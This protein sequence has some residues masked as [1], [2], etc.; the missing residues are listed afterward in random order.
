[1]MVKILTGAFSGMVSGIILAVFGYAKNA[2]EKF[3]FR[4]SA[5]T[6]IL[7]VFVGLVAVY[8]GITYFETQDWFLTVGALTLFEYSLK[9]FWRRIVLP[10][11]RKFRR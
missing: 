10:I 3:N 7:G 9:T 6:V 5:Q 2:G 11:K 4:K 1:M 8:Q